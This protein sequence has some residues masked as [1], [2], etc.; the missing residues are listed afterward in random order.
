MSSGTLT[1]DFRSARCCQIAMTIHADTALRTTGS[2]GPES[3]PK[4]MRVNSPGASRAHGS[5]P[6]IVGE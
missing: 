6:H 4:R 2:T 1:A 3:P 5:V